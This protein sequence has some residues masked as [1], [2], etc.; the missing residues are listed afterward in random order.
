MFIKDKNKRKVTVGKEVKNK[1]KLVLTSR[2]D[3][4]KRKD[5][6]RNC[7]IEEKEVTHDKFLSFRP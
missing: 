1:K 3:S 6:N 4:S 2:K 7:K 5:D